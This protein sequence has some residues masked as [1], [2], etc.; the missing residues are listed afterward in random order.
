VIGS[1]TARQILPCGHLVPEHEKLTSG[2][3]AGVTHGLQMTVVVGVGTVGVAETVTVIGSH[4]ARQISPGGHLVLKHEKLTFGDDA[5]ATHGLQMT[6]VVGVGTA[7]ALLSMMEH[8]RLLAVDKGR[9][10]GNAHK[11]DGCE[12]SGKGRVKHGDL[13]GRL[14][15]R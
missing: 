5:G 12:N 2:D 4:T 15:S 8:I 1:H 13:K 7:I 10:R 11:R 3:D 9:R 6:V 14:W